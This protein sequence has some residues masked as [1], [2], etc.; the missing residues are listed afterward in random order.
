MIAVAPDCDSGFNL[1]RCD[2]TTC[3]NGG[4]APG[5][6]VD[7]VDNALTGLGPV[8]AGVGGNLGGVDQALYDGLCDGTI[9]WVFEV[10]TNLAENCATVL[11]LY[12]GTQAAPVALNFSGAIPNHF[13][14][15]KNSQAQRMA[16]SLK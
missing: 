9:D 13:L 8:F 11:P 16:S 1:D 12:G 7:G 10:D 6:G 4:L 5:E 3:I 2:G 15:V 14:S